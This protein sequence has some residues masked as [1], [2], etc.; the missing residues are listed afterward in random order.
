[1]QGGASS[2]QT[3]VFELEVSNFLTFSKFIVP[4]TV[5]LGDVEGTTGRISPP[6]HSSN[7]HNAVSV[8]DNHIE[9]FHLEMP[10]V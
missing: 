1:M 6:T 9:N 2:V 8:K 5:I 10:V 7:I 4:F 3:Q